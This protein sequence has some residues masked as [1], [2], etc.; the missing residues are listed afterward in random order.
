MDQSSVKNKIQK[1][2]MKALISYRNQDPLTKIKDN[3]SDLNVVEVYGSGCGFGLQFNNSRL[4]TL[5]CKTEV[6]LMVFK[7]KLFNR[8]FGDY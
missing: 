5:V 8:I 7:K 2:Q 3:Y 6:H 4:N 1:K